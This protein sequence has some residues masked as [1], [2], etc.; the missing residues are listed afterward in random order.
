MTDLKANDKGYYQSSATR[1]VKIGHR[2]GGA[3]LT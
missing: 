2:D 3:R 1:R